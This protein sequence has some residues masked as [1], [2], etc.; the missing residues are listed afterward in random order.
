MARAV[1]TPHL[2]CGGPDDAFSKFA[3][4]GEWSIRKFG[5]YPIAETTRYR[6]VMMFAP[7]SVGAKV[8]ENVA[9]PKSGQKETRWNCTAN[10]G[11]R[12][13]ISINR[14]LWPRRANSAAAD[15]SLPLSR[16][17]GKIVR[18]YSRPVASQTRPAFPIWDRNG[19]DNVIPFP[20]AASVARV[21][22]RSIQGDND[23]HYRMLVN[24]L[25]AAVLVVLVVSG[26]WMFS[27]L[28]TI[29]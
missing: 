2:H 23:Y 9:M 4:H 15:E 14:T 26:E 25:A 6:S 28:A 10:D 18:F 20:H 22:I 11:D 13:S 8:Q 16:G 27:T 17:G 12:S 3:P 29:H 5:T 7:A 21:E 19:K 24:A 1:G